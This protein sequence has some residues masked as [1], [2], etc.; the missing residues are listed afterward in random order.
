MN[1]GYAEKAFEIRESFDRRV[2]KSISL[3][4]FVCVTEILKKEE[5]KGEDI[6]LHRPGSLFSPTRISLAQLTRI[7]HAL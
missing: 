2:S 3:H 4:F 7:Q 5:S 6:E 1:S